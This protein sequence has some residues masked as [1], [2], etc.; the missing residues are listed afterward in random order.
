VSFALAATACSNS[1]SGADA[2]TDSPNDNSQAPAS[3]LGDFDCA[4]GD[5]HCFF[6]IDAGCDKVG[7]PGICINYNAPD[8]CAPTIACGCDDT[9]ISVCSPAGYVPRYASGAG[10]CP[11]VDSGVDAGMDATDDADDA[12]PE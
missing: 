12:S 4:N 1:G 3:C 6:P 5:D 10:A 2:S 8:A 11:F 7:Q 9:T